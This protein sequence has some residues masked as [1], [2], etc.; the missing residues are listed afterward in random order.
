MNWIDD[1]Q[2]IDFKGGTGQF[3]E[4]EIIKFIF[5]HLP[6]TNKYFVDI[7]AGYYGHGLMSN[8]LPL[9]EQ[10]W[11]GL[12]VD[13]N[14]DDD[15]SIHKL[16]VTPENI[17]PFLTEQGVPHGFD[18]LSI[19]I[20][21]FDLDVMEAV[22]KKYLPRVICTEINTCLPV[23]SSLKLK[24]EPGYVWDETSKYGY[25]F[26]A[27]VRFCEKYG[28][29]I[30]LNHINQNLFLVRGDLIADSDIPE[31]YCEQTNYH[32]WNKNAEWEEYV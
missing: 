26:G 28:Y 18:L 11:E 15:G 12:R 17:V 8:T 2:K 13:A 7:G 21:S 9:L 6:T 14:N 20:D 25:S 23:E 29:I 31:I 22:V 1:L 27:A 16:Y 32:P 10:G 4:S 5:Q 19:D 30:L 3:G 24:Y